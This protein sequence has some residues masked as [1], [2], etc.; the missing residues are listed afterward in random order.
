MSRIALFFCIFWITAQ[1]GN[2]VA[3]ATGGGMA[4]QLP[5]PAKSPALLLS[6]ADCIDIV[7]EK[8]PGLAYARA[9]REEKEA[10][11]RSAEKDLY[12][13]LFFQYEYR[14][15]YD[16]AFEVGDFFPTVD[17]YY[18]YTFAIEQPLYRGKALVTAVKQNKLAYRYSDAA[19]S[20]AQIEQIFAVYNA[21]FNFLKAEKLED[22]ARQALSRLQSHARDAR[23]FFAAG[24]IPKNDLLT[25]EVE[26]AQG[27]QD[28]LK[29][30]NRIQLAGAA[31]NIML[32]RPAV[33]PLEVRDILIYEPRQVSWD[34]VRRLA[35]HSRPEIA[36]AKIAT[37]QAEEDIVLTRAPYLPA[38]TLSAAYTKRGD[39]FFADEYP[40]GS[41]EIK[42]A[43]AVAQWR[44]WPWGQKKSKMA[45]ARRRLRKSKELAAQVVDKVI[46]EVRAAFLEIEEAAENIEVAQKAIARADENYR[47]NEARYQAQLNTTTEVIDAHNLLSRAKTNYYNALYDY[48]MAKARLD[49]AIGTLHHNN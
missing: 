3:A 41:S 45:A 5:P 10:S 14:R 26:T 17:N 8:S 19:Y 31:L 4:D 15:D 35:L 21:Y 27:R 28:L 23:A 32:K 29:A 9:D 18:G 11:L 47:I 49:R 40:L 13:T 25:S 36:Q 24:L 44:F 6:L 42:S 33:S 46:L 2:A 34:E 1:A 16:N 20:K 38:V 48:N 37:R 43:R 39:T 7:L 12:P 22:E 30:R